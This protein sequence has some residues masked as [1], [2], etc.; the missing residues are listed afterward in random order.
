MGK[1]GR[2]ALVKIT[3]SNAHFESHA[4]IPCTYSHAHNARNRVNQPK[5]MHRKFI[6]DVAIDV[7]DN[8]N[9]GRIRSRSPKTSKKAA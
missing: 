7:T 8:Y 4:D 9:Q 6:S 1:D 2:R 5:F 3:A